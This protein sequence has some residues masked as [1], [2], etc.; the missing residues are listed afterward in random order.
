MG[1]YILRR[2]IAALFVVWGVTTVVFLILHVTSD[3][4]D[5]LLPPNASQADYDALKT[6]LGLDAPLPIQYLRFLAGAATLNF[7]S[8]Y[9]YGEPAFGVVLER[10]PVSLQLTVTALALAIL[11]AVPAGVIS[12]ANRG[13]LL[14]RFTS[15]LTFLGQSVPVFWLGAMM[16]IVFGVQLGWFP[17]S[18]ATSWWH[19]VMPATALAVYPLAQLTRL[20]RSEMLEVLQQ[21]YV[22]TARAKGLREWVVL[23]RHA[24]ANAA[25]PLVTMVGLNF[26]T[27]LGGAVI[28]ETIF[29]WPGVGRLTLQ[30]IANRDFPV[31]EAGVATLAMV[32]VLINLLVDILY[33]TLDPRVR[34]S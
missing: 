33:A 32:V 8:S 17:T 24:L 23:R 12:A 4:V 30:A 28:T 14:D 16:I 5:L 20:T 26:G 10:Y 18:G 25:I 21:D 19:L 13:T 22:R 1:R 29:A 7:G 31:V 3:P 6:R 15:S 11:V 34:V 2:L 9:R 27:L